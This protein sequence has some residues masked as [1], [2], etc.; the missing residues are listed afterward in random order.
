MNAPISAELMPYSGNLKYMIAVLYASTFSPQNGIYYL[1]TIM[2][3]IWQIN[4][5]K[6]KNG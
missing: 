1:T 5:L 6:G 2:Y 3:T 4:F